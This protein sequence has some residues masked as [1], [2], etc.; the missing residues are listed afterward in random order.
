VRISGISTNDEALKAQVQSLNGSKVIYDKGDDYIVVVGL[1]DKSFTQNTGSVSVKRTMPDL[2]FITEAENRLWG[3]KYGLVNGETVNEI[4]CCALGDFKNWNQFLGLATDSYVASV[5]TDGPWTGAV[6]HLGYPIFFKENC[7]HKVYVSSQGAHQIVDTACRGVQK[8]SH[9]SLAVVNER[10]YYKAVTDVM[11]YDGSLPEAISAQMGTERYFDAVAGSLGDKYYISMKDAANKWH[12]FV[13]DTLKG[14]W[15][16]EDNTRAVQFARCNGE[17]YYIDGDNKALMSVGGSMGEP[18]RDVEWMAMT[19]IMGYT[20]V[21]QK[22]V[23]RF[24]LRMK[25]PVGSAMDIYIQYD[26]DGV[27]EHAGHINGTGT[28]TFMLPVRPRRCDH[29]QIKMEGKGD[30]R[31]YSLAKIHERGSDM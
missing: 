23:I 20:T 14:F 12:L 24:N 1:L 2:D 6:T 28:K 29:F 4:Y 16:R 25:L 8:G 7:L 21:E 22:Y 5:G 26:S 30:V 15:H 10:L 3:C 11:V 27:W 9:N 18:E 19:G 13:C 17:L 31:I